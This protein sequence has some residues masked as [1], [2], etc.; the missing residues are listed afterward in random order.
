VEGKRECI[1]WTGFNAF[2]TCIAIWNNLMILHNT[3]NGSAGAFFYAFIATGALVSV[4]M[5]FK[6][7]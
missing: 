1:F 2:T 6:K 4:F 3:V 5:N 7:T